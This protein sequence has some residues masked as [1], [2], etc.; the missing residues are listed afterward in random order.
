MTMPDERMKSLRWAYELL[1]EIDLDQTIRGDLRG[2]ARAIASRFPTPEELQALI[3]SNS[4]SLPGSFAEAI[5]SARDLFTDIQGSSTG[6]S[7]TRKSVLYTLRH[8]PLRGHAASRT[9]G[10]GQFGIEDWIARAPT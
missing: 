2:R 1:A 9:R 10:W 7:T 5:E 6:S 4:T 8:Y 3:T